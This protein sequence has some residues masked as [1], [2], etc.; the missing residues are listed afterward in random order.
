MPVYTSPELTLHV[1]GVAV[2]TKTQAMRNIPNLAGEAGKH[3]RRDLVKPFFSPLVTDMLIKLFRAK[4]SA[5]RRLLIT[6]TFPAGTNGQGLIKN[7]FV[8]NA[9]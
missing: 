7:T 4:E 1:P 3:V 2:I 8:L 9:S 6:C 5:C